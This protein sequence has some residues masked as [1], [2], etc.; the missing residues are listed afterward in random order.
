MLFA[1]KIL[2][3]SSFLQEH[4]YGYH[5]DDLSLTAGFTPSPYDLRP[6]GVLTYD[7]V[8]SKA[9]FIP[10]DDFNPKVGQLNSF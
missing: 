10:Y 5:I 7:D 4:R 1:N 3:T 8:S 2:T 9:G 6:A